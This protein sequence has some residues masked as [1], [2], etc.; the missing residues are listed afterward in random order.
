MFNSSMRHERGIRFKLH[1]PRKPR[2]PRC[3][4]VWRILFK[5]HLAH[6]CG[7]NAPM[8]IGLLVVGKEKR[9]GA[10][11]PGYAAGELVRG[12]NHSLWIVAV[13]GGTPIPILLFGQLILELYR[14]HGLVLVVQ[15]LAVE[16]RLPFRIPSNLP[17][18]PVI[19]FMPSSAPDVETLPA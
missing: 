4:P 1:A 12:S 15:K 3:G 7:L 5:P 11:S 18:P 8:V 17:V 14:A 6:P 19:L 16:Q 9:L 2:S 13:I 10:G